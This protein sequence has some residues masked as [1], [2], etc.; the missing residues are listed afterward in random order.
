MAGVSIAASTAIPMRTITLVLG[1]C[2][3]IAPARASSLLEYLLPRHPLQVVTVT[4][5]LPEGKDRAAPSPQHPVYF[6]PVSAG[7]YDFG[8]S[9]AGE[10]PVA[11]EEVTKT[12]YKVL[13]KQ[14]YLP[15]TTRHQPDIILVWVWGSL[16]TPTIHFTSSIP[17]YNSVK[18]SAKA[19]SFMG[20]EKV[21]LRDSRL[22]PFSDLLL[23]TGLMRRSDTAQAIYD[24]AHDDLY[25]AC[26]VAYDYRAAATG[27]KVLLWR[28]R[29]STPSLGFWLPEALPSMLAIASPFFGRETPQPV[30]IDAD[31]KYRPDITL[32][33]PK[34]LGYSEDGAP[35]QDTRRFQ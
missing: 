9:K 20:G 7:Y 17:G 5:V 32:G 26:V 31:D 12:M 14:G 24:A 35:A 27:R 21:G 22:D 23:P 28:T 25:T 8:P 13:A 2:A 30:W 3:I 18:L 1:F 6:L 16:N 29:I 11:P 15:A 34:V 10:R 19:V 33:D 4:D